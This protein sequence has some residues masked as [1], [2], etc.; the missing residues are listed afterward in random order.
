MSATS[1]SIL[2]RWDGGR[3]LNERLKLNRVINNRGR[4]YDLLI[5]LLD[6]PAKATLHL[7]ESLYD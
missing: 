1:K 3:F 4:V 5:L 7:R 6:C 2:S